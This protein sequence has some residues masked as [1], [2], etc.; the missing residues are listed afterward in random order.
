MVKIYHEYSTILAIDNKDKGQNSGI[1][2]TSHH[3]HVCTCIWETL[4]LESSRSDDNFVWL[5]SR[6]SGVITVTTPQG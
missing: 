3:L 6:R 5:S 4:C 2:F 1:I